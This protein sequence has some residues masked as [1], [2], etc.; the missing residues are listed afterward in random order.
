M[1]GLMKK[2]YI[3]SILFE[4]LLL[5]TI[6]TAAVTGIGVSVGRLFQL[7][8]IVMF[9]VMFLTKK[10]PIRIFNPANPIYSPYLIYFSYTVLISVIGVI[11]GSYTLQVQ[12]IADIDYSSFGG[13]SRSL[14][15]RPF[16]EIIISFYYFLYYV[17]AP[18]YLL[19]NSRDID[20]FFKAFHFVFVL[21]IFFGV[22]DLVFAAFDYSWIPR[23]LNYDNYSNVG[24][25]F[26]SFAGEPRD[27]FV[28]LIFGASIY[29]LGNYWNTKIKVTKYGLILIIVLLVLTKSGSGVLGLFMSAGLIAIYGVLSGSRKMLLR[30]ILAVFILFLIIYALSLAPRLQLYVSVIQELYVVLDTG[31]TIPFHIQGQMPNIYPL[32]ELYQNMRNWNPLPLLFGSGVGTSPIVNSN[33]GNYTD[34]SNPHSQIVRTLYEVGLVGLMLFILAFITPVKRLTMNVSNN[35]KRMFLFII[36]FLISAFLA[37][38]S[39]LLYIYLGLFIAVFSQKM[40]ADNSKL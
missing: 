19:R 11:I 33:L 13:F 6:G 29:L 32:W 27:A 12:T 39:L 31:G 17:V 8:F 14:Y 4:P 38:R 5:F 18:K 35:K 2:V 24:F 23:Q 9:I 20:Y 37:H 26:H 21:F 30:S 28:Y 7:L 22:V 25:R 1:F 34:L 16:I 3:W 15:V 36:I 10:Y 40:A